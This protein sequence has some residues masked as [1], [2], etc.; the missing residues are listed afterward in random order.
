M[1]VW[2][3]LK[4]SVP[5][6]G[7]LRASCA[8]NIAR[9]HYTHCLVLPELWFTGTFVCGIASSA[10]KVQP[11]YHVQSQLQSQ[12]Y[13]KVKHGRACIH[14][15]CCICTLSQVT[16]LVLCRVF[17]F[18]LQRMVGV[19]DVISHHLDLVGYI[20]CSAIGYISQ[21]SSAHTDSAKGGLCDMSELFRLPH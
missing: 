7:L 21:Y 19:C 15:G 17:P 20:V 11:S 4:H 18:R 8:F 16:V 6:I 2:H 13:I 3:S 14:G 5:P 10:M 1:Y 12:L 9:S